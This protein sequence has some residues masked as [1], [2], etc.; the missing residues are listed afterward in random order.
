[1]NPGEDPEKTKEILARRIRDRR[2]KIGLTQENLAHL[3]QI[4]RPHMSDIETGRSAPEIWT[5]VRIAGVLGTT[6]GQLLRGLKWT[7]SEDVSA[8]L[9]DPKG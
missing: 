7:P 9:K 8:Y 3:A 4:N 5:L 2:R 1:M 6:S